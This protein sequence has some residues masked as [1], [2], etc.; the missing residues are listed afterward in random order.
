MTY[1]FKTITA[2]PR[3]KINMIRKFAGSDIHRNIAINGTDE[4]RNIQRQAK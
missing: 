3:D 2:E 1:E 4:N